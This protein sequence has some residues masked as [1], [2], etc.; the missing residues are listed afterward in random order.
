MTKRQ[1][2]ETQFSL[3]HVLEQMDDI[4]T[5]DCFSEEE[6]EATEARDEPFMPGSDDEFRDCISEESDEEMEGTPTYKLVGRSPTSFAYW[7]KVGYQA[8]TC[9]WYQMGTNPGIGLI[10]D[11]PPIRPGRAMP[12]Y[13][14]TFK[15]SFFFVF[16]S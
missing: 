12:N 16:F 3:D 7:R 13:I 9:T 6:E 10:P 14:Q 11:L 8:Y 2:A 4:C 5:L 1:R 15:K